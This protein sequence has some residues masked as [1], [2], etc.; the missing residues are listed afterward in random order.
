MKSAVVALLSLCLA[1]TGCTTTRLVPLSERPAEGRP[2][3]RIGE[4]LHI[5]LKT[6]EELDLK[7]TQ[8]ATGTV[9]GKRLSA[10]RGATL[11]IAMSEVQGM[12]ARRFEAGK[13]VGLVLGVAAGLVVLAYA[14]A[15]AAL[16]SCD[17]CD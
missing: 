8:V 11:Q 1:F 2:A 12:S 15:L 5:T 14:A 6:G 10:P 17:D 16:T 3:V 7:V 9:T 13:T 4:R